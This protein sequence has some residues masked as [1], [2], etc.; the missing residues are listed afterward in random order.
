MEPK[1]AG[2][3]ARRGRSGGLGRNVGD[4]SGRLSVRS[5]LDNLVSAGL[6]VGSVTTSE[7][8]VLYF[9]AFGFGTFSRR[10]MNTLFE[11]LIDDALLRYRVML[12][13][14]PPCRSCSAV[15]LGSGRRLLGCG[16]VRHLTLQ[17]REKTRDL[18]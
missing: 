13:S 6:V 11:L 5:P 17:P 1:T 3:G 12:D 4:T 10:K 8:L 18:P 14:S 16:S 2:Q 7:Y 9:F 15:I